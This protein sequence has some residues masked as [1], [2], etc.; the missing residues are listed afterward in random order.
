MRY[1]TYRFISILI[2]LFL[3]CLVLFSQNSNNGSGSA[4]NLYSEGVALFN[5]GNYGS[6]LHKFEELQAKKAGL[7]SDASAYYIAASRLELGNPN[8][9]AEL[10][11]FVE[12]QPE[13]PLMNAA[14]FR[15]ANLS[16]DQKKYKA[17]PETGNRR[18]NKC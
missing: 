11:K 15:M 10:K 8:G 4:S 16:F 6:A 3:S 14:L 5:A 17:I 9:E 12:D 1:N 2:P 13:S 7:L 18:L